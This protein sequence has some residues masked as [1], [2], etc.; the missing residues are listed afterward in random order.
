MGNPKSSAGNKRSPSQDTKT[1]NNLQELGIEEHH[2]VKY[3]FHQH[4]AWLGGCERIITS[5]FVWNMLEAQFYCHAKAKEPSADDGLGLQTWSFALVPV[6]LMG[7]WHRF[8]P[9]KRQRESP[10][11]VAITDEG[12]CRIGHSFLSMSHKGKWVRIPRG[13]HNVFTFEARRFVICKDTPAGKT[14]HL[15]LPAIPAFE[16]C[17][18]ALHFI[19]PRRFAK[20]MVKLSHKG[21]CTSPLW[22]LWIHRCFKNKPFFARTCHTSCRRLFSFWHVL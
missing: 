16:M 14:L 7:G 18:D 12:N 20:Q 9:N 2:Y 21:M 19:Q 6:T 3:I 8:I 11:L 4:G 17:S 22:T 5:I 13:F 15:P 1:I 10:K